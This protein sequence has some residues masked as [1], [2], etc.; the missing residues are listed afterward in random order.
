LVD[1][2]H[3]SLRKKIITYLHLFFLFLAWLA[4]CSQELFKIK[5]HFIKVVGRQFFQM[6]V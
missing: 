6:K 4:V 2:F 1:K 3:V 5:D